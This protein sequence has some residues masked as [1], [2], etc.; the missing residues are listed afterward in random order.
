[1]WDESNGKI[2]FLKVFIQ[3]IILFDNDVH[4]SDLILS[5]IKDKST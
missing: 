2:K 1:M 3:F 4:N 5:L